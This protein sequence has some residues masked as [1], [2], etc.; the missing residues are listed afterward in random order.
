MPY[1]PGYGKSIAGQFPPLRLHISPAGLSV[2]RFG[3]S[4]CHDSRD[5]CRAGLLHL[6]WL[7]AFGSASPGGGIGPASA[8]TWDRPDAAPGGKLTRWLEAAPVGWLLLDDDLQVHS[9]HAKGRAVAL[10]IH[11]RPSWC[12]GAS[13]SVSWSIKRSGGE[14]VHSVLRP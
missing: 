13:P 7:C 5:R 8:R 3:D 14:P 12:A 11:D 4:S 10:N 2:Y 1:P 6:A 9:I